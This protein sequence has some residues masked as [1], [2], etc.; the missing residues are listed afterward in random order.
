[1]AKLPIKGNYDMTSSHVL[2]VNHVFEILLTYQSNGNNWKDAFSKVIPNR[3]VARA[4]E[5]EDGGEDAPV[6]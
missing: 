6:V 5:V 3:K 2:T 1:M 4:K